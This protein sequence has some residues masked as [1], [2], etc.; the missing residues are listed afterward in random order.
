MQHLLDAIESEGVASTGLH[1]PD[2]TYFR[3]FDDFR[4]KAKEFRSP[5]LYEAVC[6]RVGGT[7]R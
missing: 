5:D 1:H 6:L 3:F 7:S 4:E 2:P